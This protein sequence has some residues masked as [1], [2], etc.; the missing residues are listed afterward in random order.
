MPSSHL[1]D[2]VRTSVLNRYWVQLPDNC[3]VWPGCTAGT[4]DHYYHILLSWMALTGQPTYPPQHVGPNCA[5]Q[6]DMVR[7]QVRC[8]V[9]SVPDTPFSLQILFTYISALRIQ[10]CWR[11]PS[12]DTPNP[13]VSKIGSSDGTYWEADILGTVR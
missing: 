13:P 4:I 3:T 7:K 12:R 2:G 10:V 8:T 11:P 6:M 1:T 5:A 9:L